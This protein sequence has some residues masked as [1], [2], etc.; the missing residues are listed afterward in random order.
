M[1]EIK[2]IHE[3]LK[4]ENKSAIPHAQPVPNAMKD[5]LKDVIDLIPTIHTKLDALSKE[6]KTQDKMLPTTQSSTPKG[7]Q[8]RT[9]SPGP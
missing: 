7:D 8:K 4:Q 5:V 6:N 3:M 2:Y 9:V 1:S